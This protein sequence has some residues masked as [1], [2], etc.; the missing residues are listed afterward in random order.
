KDI[1]EYAARCA[2]MKLYYMGKTR[3]PHGQVVEILKAFTSE[4]VEAI[5]FDEVDYTIDTIIDAMFQSIAAFFVVRNSIGHVRL[6]MWH[7]SNS[8]NSLEYI[9]FSSL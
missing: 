5:C 7:T 8:C 2:I 9:V 4:Q 1:P 3:L 6:S